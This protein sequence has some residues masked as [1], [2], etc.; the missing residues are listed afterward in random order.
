VN[1][2]CSTFGLN[3]RNTLDLLRNL[4]PHRDKFAI[5]TYTR[6]DVK[7][8]KWIEHLTKIDVS[9]I[10]FGME[11][12]S[13]EMLL[14]MGKT[15]YPADYVRRSQDLIDLYHANGI[16]LWCNFIVGYV[17]ETP[18][19]LRQTVEFILKNR[20]KIGLLT[21]S[22]LLA[23]PGTRIL[24]CR[25]ELAERYGI[26]IDPEHSIPDAFLFSVHPSIDFA[27]DQMYA[28]CNILSKI[29]NT[30]DDFVGFLSS[31]WKAGTLDVPKLDHAFGRLPPHERPYRCSRD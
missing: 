5:Q 14:A 9:C 24:E 1:L 23:Y 29:V 2:G 15:R 31:K 19:T 10:Y 30:R 7:F 22:T 16:R 6:C 26:S 8:E 18:E 25:D 3:E 4:V 20:H 21:C 13:E 11:S 12:A 28:L 27:N 17:G